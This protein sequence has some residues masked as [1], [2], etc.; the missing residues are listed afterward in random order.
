MPGDWSL[1]S[2][3]AVDHVRSA[4]QAVA[5]SKA[6]VHKFEPTPRGLP[7]ISLVSVDEVEA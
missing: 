3:R 7:E 4:R 5:R 1:R 2:A 6:T